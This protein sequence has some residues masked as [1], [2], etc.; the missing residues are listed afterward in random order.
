MSLVGIASTVSALA[1]NSGYDFYCL[2]PNATQPYSTDFLF[3]HISNPLWEAGV[4]LSGTAQWI[5]GCDPGGATGVESVPTAGSIGF[6]NGTL[7]SFQDD[8]LGTPI[9]NNLTVNWGMS[10]FGLQSGAGWSFARIYVA[11]AAGA[12]TSYRHL[13]NGFH[14]AYV[15]ESN[16]YMYCD[17]YLNSGAIAVRRVVDVI[18]DAARVTWNLSNRTAASQNLGLWFGQW[19]VLSTDGPRGYTSP[20][21]YSPG[22]QP[23]IMQERW[24][25]GVSNQFPDV[26]NF[27][28]NQSDC[29]G[30]QVVNGPSANV[31]D[32]F[33]NSDQTPVDEF[34]LGDA[35]FLLNGY[36]AT[37]TDPHFNDFIF[38]DS[39]NDASY[40]QKWNPVA[41]STDAANSWAN[42]RTITAY[43]RSTWGDSD[44]ANGYGVTVDTPKVVSTSPDDV[45]TFQTGTASVPAKI[46]VNIDNTGAFAYVQRSFT[47]TNVKVTL[48]LPQ[49]M[50]AVGNSNSQV[51][52]KYI[53]SIVPKNIGFVDFDVEVDPNVYGQKT[54]QVKVEPNPGAA[55]TITGAISVAATP[56]L[57]L[58]GG[59]NLVGSP[60]QYAD[61]TWDTILSPL[62]VNQDYQAITWD[63]QLQQYVIQTSATRSK[64]TWLIAASD[65]GTV[66]LGGTPRQ[67]DD[68]LASSSNGASAFVVYP[69]WNLIANP[70]N[71]AI[72]IS[73]ITG[74]PEATSQA[75]TWNELTPTYLG[76]ALS[77]YDPQ[78]H[79]YQ[80]A[81]G[82]PAMLQP[83]TGYW[84]YAVTKVTLQ[85]PPVFQPFVRD[86]SLTAGIT[87]F[88]QTAKDW[89]LQLGVQTSTAR[90]L[91][92]YIGVATAGTRAAK[93]SS[94]KP[95]ISPNADAV[96]GYVTN[97]AGASVQYG[98]DYRN[99]STKQ[100]WVY[101]VYTQKAGLTAVTW[102][103]IS[104]LPSNVRLTI[105]DLK[106]G[107]SVDMRR[108]SSTSYSALSKSTR[109]FLV[110][111]TP[112]GTTAL[113]IGTTR[114]QYSKSGS[115]RTARLQYVLSNSS[116]TTVRVLK[117]G[118]EVVKLA[119]D[120]V[121]AA[122]TRILSWNC[123]KGMGA[124]VDAGQ[125]VF[126]LSC[127]GPA[128][129]VATRQVPFTVGN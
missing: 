56:K 119:V 20:Y 116:H 10:R 74:V 18:G 72:P 37:V 70:Y 30:M 21:I 106:T 76:S 78:L 65:I 127:E 99:Q 61:A 94:Y 19:V 118:V 23:L 43:Y 102:P 28:L 41:V 64:G 108:S 128:G 77:Y 24:T 97:T 123:T 8:Y 101:N 80:V 69:G 113:R 120:Q 27:G 93:L 83:N 98:Q 124:P 126:E 54:Y 96:R 44:Y 17:E 9:D 111:A 51:L 81:T 129:D 115:T 67:P 46:R 49:G 103:N 112:L 109:S 86:M 58:S 33:V 14:L 34:V 4:G 62:V 22:F 125:Y 107:R 90:D 32:G 57:N 66:S 73:Q 87:G 47:M 2:D 117:N 60:W 16:R 38:P 88:R 55:K 31:S 7:G 85:F 40:I 3:Q 42:S 63:A 12:L 71:Y 5:P 13:S 6:M 15:G 25:R 75:L 100:S 91:S 48:T 89:Q 29:Y 105:K 36:K 92:T 95:P 59:A 110:E 68:Q 122:G 104:S 1:Q 45:N 35:V 84:I 50:H 53:S 82:T 52:V 39:L 11:D 114:T 26:V 79:T 121:D